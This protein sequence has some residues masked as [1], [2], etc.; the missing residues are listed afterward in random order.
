MIAVICGGGSLPHAVCAELTAEKKDF[1]VVA[2][3]PHT[4]GEQFLIHHAAHQTLEFEWYDVE[5]ILTALQSKKTH[6]VVLI[7]KFDKRCL[8]QAWKLDRLGRSLLGRVQAWGDGA[9]LKSISSFFRDYGMEVIPQEH[10]LNRQFVPANNTFSALSKSYQDDVLFGLTIAEQMSAMDISQTVIV[11]NKS[12][13]A[14]EGVEGT[15]ECIA[16]AQT[17]GVEGMVICKTAAPGLSK[18]LDIPT[19]GPDTLSIIDPTL[20]NIISWHHDRT[21]IVNSNVFF[22]T[23]RARGLTLVAT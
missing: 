10:I 14:I 9:L 7:G 12:V 13:I 4:S 22:N 3:K 8:F 20:V 17:Y 1:F 11:K 16:R 19:L 5:K 18:T 21:L 6:N 15:N 2:L 23:A